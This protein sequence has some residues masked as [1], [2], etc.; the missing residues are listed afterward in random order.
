F[1]FS[2]RRRH[3]RFSRDWSSDV[4]SSDLS[5]AAFALS[6]LSCMDVGK[7]P[8]AHELAEAIDGG[9][10]EVR[11]GQK[12]SRKPAIAFRAR[13]RF[14]TPTP[15]MWGVEASRSWD[16][17]YDRNASR[18]LLHARPLPVSSFTRE[19]AT[20]D[21]ANLAYTG[22]DVNTVPATPKLTINSPLR[23]GICVEPQEGNLS[24]WLLH[25]SDGSVIL[26]LSPLSFCED[27]VA[28]LNDS[29]LMQL[30]RRSLAVLAPN[31]ARARVIGGVGGL[32][33]NL[34]P[35]GSVVVDVRGS[36]KVTVLTQPGSKGARHPAKIKVGKSFPVA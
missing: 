22:F 17:R 28:H 4:C 27:D 10:F 23:S 33:S 25:G 31:E 15:T 30:A 8:R 20:R 34:S 36:S 3:T 16:A 2:S 11:G 14:R 29:R 6:I 32:P 21:E 35:F 7:V 24:N 26:A 19:R 12:D 9:I 5:G 13:P 1:F 18:Y